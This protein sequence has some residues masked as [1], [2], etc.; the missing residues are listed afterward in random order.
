MVYQYRD[1]VT[2]NDVYAVK[3]LIP[4]GQRRLALIYDNRI[5]IVKPADHGLGLP[6]IKVNPYC[7]PPVFDDFSN[8]NS[9][10][11]SGQSGTTTYGYQDNQYRIF[12]QYADQWLGVTAGHVWNDSDSLKVEGQVLDGRIGVWGVVFGLNNDW[13][14]F[15]TFEIVPTHQRWYIWHYSDATGWQLAGEGQHIT[16]HTS[17]WN[18]IEI[19]NYGTSLALV[20]NDYVQFFPLINGRVG[21]SGGAID[22]L[23]DIRYDNYSLI[24][25]KCPSSNHALN[26]VEP[27]MVLERPPLVIPAALP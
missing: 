21:L 12:H 23:L 19:V 3:R 9:G 27:V 15:Y 16:I 7:A 25:A 14:D 18:T 20:V 8:P 10:W 6:V 2:T 13:S 5:R 26:G 22:G 4:L 11:P 17:G 24:H 1:T